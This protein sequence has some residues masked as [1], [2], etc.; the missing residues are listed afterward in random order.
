MSTDGCVIFTVPETM[1]AVEQTKI[2]SDASLCAC[3]GW[4]ILA[5]GRNVSFLDNRVVA[6]DERLVGNSN[7]GSARCRSLE[8]GDSHAGEALGQSGLMC[9]QVS[10]C[11]ASVAITSWITLRRMT[12]AFARSSAIAPLTHPHESGASSPDRIS[13]PGFDESQE[14]R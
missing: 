14:N 3:H 1:S 9:G 11:R 5:A 7:D 12:P 4:H 2:C 8:E 6:R 13:D 10:F